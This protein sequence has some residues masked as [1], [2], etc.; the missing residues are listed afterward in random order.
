MRIIIYISYG[1]YLYTFTD[2]M[3]FKTPFERPSIYIVYV[4]K[5]MINS[6]YDLTL[7]IYGKKTLGE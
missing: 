3:F 2:F 6:S 1:I 7:P 5:A 4:R